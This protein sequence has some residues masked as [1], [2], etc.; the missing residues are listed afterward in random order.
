MLGLFKNVSANYTELAYDFEFKS[1][2]GK[3]I[4]SGG[5]ELALELEEKGY[6]NF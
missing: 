1:I 4:K 3:I 6:E 5:P 2:D